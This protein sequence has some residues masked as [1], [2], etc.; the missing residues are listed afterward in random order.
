MALTSPQDAE[1]H[2]ASRP[3]LRQ[4]RVMRVVRS[5]L[6]GVTALATLTAV[7]PAVV[8]VVAHAKPSD[9]ISMP[10]LCKGP[11]N[12]AAQR[13]FDVSRVSADRV[14]TFDRK[15]VKLDRK[16]WA[17]F[18]PRDPSWTLWFHSLA[19]LVPLALDEPRTA[20]DVFVERDKALPDPGASVGNRVR[21]P[22]GWTQGQFRTRLDV[23][24]CLY[25]LTDDPRLV[26]IAKRLAAA[27]MD[28][29]RY[30]GPP[31]FAVHNHGTMGNITLMQAGKTFGQQAWIDF[32]L[33][34]FKRDLPYVFE[35]CGMMREQSST[36][37]LHNLK[38]WS[39]TAAQLG[40]SLEA[41]RRALGA[42]VR[43]DGVLE[44]I[45]DGQP[46]SGLEP[47]GESL[48]CRETGWAAGTLPGGATSDDTAG[49]A[50]FTLRFGPRMRFHGHL[51]HGSL[52]WFALGAPV[53]SDRGLFSKDRGPRFDYAH[54]MAAHSV[55]EPVGSPKY[56]PATS[57]TRI[58]PTEYSLRDAVDGIE[59][60][61][62]V[63]IGP[64]RLV[65]RDR[66]RGAKEW[67]QHWQLAPGWEPTATGAVNEA[68]GLTLTID[69]PKLKPVRV[70][71][72]TAWRTAVD[73]WD[74]Q[75]RVSGDRTGA[76]LTTT[77]TVMPTS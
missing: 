61:R 74:I 40:T 64:D 68:A 50:H 22:I 29:L 6:V 7:V 44:A 59:R 63:R 26:P 48:W 11:Y 3:S 52:T 37:Q 46:D 31:N 39:K 70:E 4:N 23:A 14:V 45:G 43:P 19:W 51:D 57:A 77:L 65:V 21:R 24:N 25:N 56:D 5:L 17:S 75:C 71:A 42:L 2:V 30:P 10:G 62:D 36:Y 12:A 33:K 27:N 69:C 18:N 67:I 32:A 66:G 49:D 47:N 60:L 55:F 8:P 16:G 34:R 41:E 9:G 53:L 38:L 72:F 54:T 1:G 35:S 15:R 73:A 76:R 58:S 20:V 28:P 13:G